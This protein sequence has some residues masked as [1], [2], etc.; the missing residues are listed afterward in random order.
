[1][2]AWARGPTSIETKGSA[3]KML[4]LPCPCCG[5]RDQSEFAYGGAANPRLPPLNGRSGQADWHEAVHR[6]ANPRGPHRELWYHAM[7]CESWIE[8]ER[9]TQTHAILSARLPL[10]QEE[11]E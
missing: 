8:V 9:D 5:L 3:S 1:M 6:R 11:E 10:S 4:L 7:G 2:R